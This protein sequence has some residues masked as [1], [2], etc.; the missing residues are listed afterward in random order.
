MSKTTSELNPVRPITVEEYAQLEGIERQTAYMR[1]YHG[2]VEARK[3]AGGRW[4]IY[5]EGVERSSNKRLAYEIEAEVT[6]NNQ[7]KYKIGMNYEELKQRLLSNDPLAIIAGELG[8]SR[9]GLSFIY[10]KYFEPFMGTGRTRRRAITERE[11]QAR[12]ES[13]FF[14]N[15]RL[16]DV[17]ERA[18]KLG[19]VVK[20]LPAHSGNKPLNNRL[21]IN[22]Y[23]CIVYRK[24]L[25]DGFSS[26]QV[27][28]RFT[29]SRDVT[30]E[31][32]YV[33]LTMGREKVD[34]LVVPSDLLL[35]HIGNKIYK[36]FYVPPGIHYKDS[37]RSAPIIRWE[38]FLDNWKQ[39]EE[40]N[41]I[42]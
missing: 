23:R 40:P 39:L 38:P 11:I 33:I 32:E 27:Y 1:V 18:S 5:P 13:K 15:E 14:A 7:R 34:M 6:F 2:S 8:I 9:Q 16:I 31:T 22:G 37:P 30:S 3:F 25:V 20:P 26:G 28:Y 36:F 19:M 42:P 17:V 29:V 41:A 21:L 4:L 35:E 10:N 12:I 24:W